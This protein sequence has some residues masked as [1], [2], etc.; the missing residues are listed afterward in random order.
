MVGDKLRRTME[1]VRSVEP[2]DVV[3]MVDIYVVPGVSDKDTRTR[4]ARIVTSSD[5]Y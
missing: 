5:S 4:V 2:V 1:P 3:H